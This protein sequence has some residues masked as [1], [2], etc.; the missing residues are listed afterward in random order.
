MARSLLA[1]TRQDG[2]ATSPGK[3][4]RVRPADV[5]VALLGGAP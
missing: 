4:L 3:W 1:P 2:E 5:P